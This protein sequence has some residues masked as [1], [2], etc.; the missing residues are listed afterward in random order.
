MTT[1]TTIQAT[2]YMK[3]GAAPVDCAAV[4]GADAARAVA[5]GSPTVI[6]FAGIRGVSS[7]FFNAILVVLRDQV[8]IDAA[9]R[10]VSFQ[11]DSN[12]QKFVLDRSINAVWG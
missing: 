11:T 1:S 4:L 8:G 5:A 9:K 12:A 10:L 3:P 2:K 7:S 6:S